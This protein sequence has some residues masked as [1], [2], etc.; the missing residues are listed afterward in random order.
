MNIKDLHVDNDLIIGRGDSYHLVLKS[1]LNF[2]YP[3]EYCKLG[4]IYYHKL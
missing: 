3:K 2:T 4:I 1:N